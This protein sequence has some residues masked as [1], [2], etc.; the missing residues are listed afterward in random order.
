MHT[1]ILIIGAGPAGFNAAKAASTSGKKTVLAGSEPW[2]PYWRPR[3][4]EIIRSG[5][6]VGGI[7][8]QQAGWYHTAGIEVMTRKTAARI[9]TT[10]KTVFWN[11]GTT[12]GY[13]SLILA[14]GAASNIP[15]FPYAEQIHVLRTYEDALSIRD[16]CAR[17][18]RAFVIGGGVLGL[19]TAF[20]IAETGCKVNVSDISEYPLPRQL[21]KEGGLFLQK[22]LEQKGIRIFC[23]VPP[24]KLKDDIEGACVIAAAGV[25][26]STALAAGC[27]IKTNR[28]IIVDSHMK[29]SEDTV[30]ACG[31]VAEF[32]GI[33]PGLLTIAA[34]QG[35]TAGMNASGTA[36]EYTP[37]LPSPSIKVA[38]VSV[39]S[40]GSMAVPSGAKMYRQSGD[41]NYAAGVILDGKLTG[42]SFIGDISAGMKI[43]HLMENR[44]DMSAVASFADILAMVS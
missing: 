22:L 38:G 21:D 43:R 17:T 19:E 27:G 8:M 41:G 30:Y 24:E 33:M 12:T 29:T 4:P 44:T 14:C 26:A 13:D 20:A 31:D 34:E 36:I 23:A 10:G 3:L 9:D 11:D 35:K 39:L 2:L 25:H 5:A 28:G 1:D 15:K 40:L 16:D 42:A 37:V 7:L 6:P 32:S 18:G